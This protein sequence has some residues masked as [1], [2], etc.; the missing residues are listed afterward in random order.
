[1]AAGLSPENCRL[2]GHLPASGRPLEGIEFRLTPPDNAPPKPAK[3]IVRFV[4]DWQLLGPFPDPSKRGHAKAY[5]PE[6][7]KIELGKMYD[8]VQGKISWRLH[9]TDKDVIDLGS[10]YN[11]RG[12]DKYRLQPDPDPA[13]RLAGCGAGNAD[14]LY[15]A[16]ADRLCGDAAHLPCA[17]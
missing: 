10:F 1:M 2:G 7:D 5:P 12:A 14:C 6:K 11:Y 15:R 8:G 3:D 17:V 9:H 13:L 4:H 16:G